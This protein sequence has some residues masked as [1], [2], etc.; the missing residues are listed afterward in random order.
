MDYLPLEVGKI[1]LVS[2]RNSDSAHARG[3]EIHSRWRAKSAGADYQHLCV[4]Q[5][6]L[7]LC[8]DFLEDYVTRIALQ[9]FVCECHY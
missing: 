4:E 1:H 9:L 3:C 8:A 7:S 5:L 2:V 6:L